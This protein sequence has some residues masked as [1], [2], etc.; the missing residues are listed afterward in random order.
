MLKVQK[1]VE[2]ADM[3]EYTNGRY[4]EKSHISCILAEVIIYI[5]IK[6]GVLTTVI[7][8]ICITMCRWCKRKIGKKERKK[9]YY[10]SNTL[11]KG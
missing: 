8:I 4:T 1:L 6:R 5:L 10:L 3:A 11:K 9:N 7:L 2:E